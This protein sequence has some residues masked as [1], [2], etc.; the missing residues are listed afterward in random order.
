MLTGILPVTGAYILKKS[1]FVYDQEKFRR[2][3]WQATNGYRHACENFAEIVEHWKELGSKF[4]NDQLTI[5]GSDAKV[6]V[7]F[8]GKN[9]TITLLPLLLDEKITALAFISAKNP[10]SG[11]T[12]EVGRFLIDAQ[13][14]IFSEYGEELINWETDDRSYR[15]LIAVTRKVLQ[16]PFKAQ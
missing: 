14:N 6:S 13:G 9:F 10:L 16:H 11:E 12:S 3:I 4:L 8:A 1:D 15:L 5:E 7:D 2:D